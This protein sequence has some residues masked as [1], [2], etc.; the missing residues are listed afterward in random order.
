MSRLIIQNQIYLL[1]ELAESYDELLYAPIYKSRVQKRFVEGLYLELKQFFPSLKFITDLQ[2]NTEDHV[3]STNATYEKRAF[4]NH[5]LAYENRL[6]DELPFDIPNSF[7]SFRKKV[8]PLLPHLFEK[9]RVP[10]LKNIREAIDSYFSNPE[11]VLNYFNTRNALIG[12]N[13]S[14]RFS[15]PLA[16]GLVD[17]R[18]LY[19]CVKDF[20]KN[21]HSNKSTY[22]IIF[23]LLWREFF[24]W[25]YQKHQNLYFSKNGIQGPKDFSQFK[26]YEVEELMTNAPSDFFKSALKELTHTGFLS[27]RAR[28]MFASQWI[29]DLGLDWRSGADFF[30][31][32]LLDFDVYSNYGNWM[33]LAGVGVDPRGKRYFNIKKQLLEYDPKGQY[34]DYWLNQ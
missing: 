22:W 29:N 32:Y 16:H 6:L 33:Y 8:E 31:T 11:V 34:L 17:I 21:N 18:Y 5:L 3:L 28:Q 24:F 26:K 30:E 25:H 27:N 20:E 4:G 10:F 13:Y 12:E 7:T 14:T 19:N 1:P 15:K 2:I 23:E 9:V